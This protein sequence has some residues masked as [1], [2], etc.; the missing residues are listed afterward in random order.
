WSRAAPLPTPRDHLAVQAIDGRIVAIGGRRDGDPAHNLSTTQVYDPTEDSWREA[1]PL[2]T[3]RSGSASAV[4]GREV[5]VIGGESTTRTFG[6]VEAF[7]LQKDLWRCLARLPTPRH[8][9]GAVTFEGRIYT[10]TG[11][12]KP[13]GEKSA[14]VE[15][16][17]P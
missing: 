16:L 10:L 12:P 1:A 6:E 8:G 9:F 2:P 4:L 5:F 13:G 15:V 14:T 7:D 17:K 11:S 3:A